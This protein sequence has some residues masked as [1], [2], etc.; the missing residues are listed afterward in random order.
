MSEVGWWQAEA[1]EGDLQMCPELLKG[2]SH[3]L[4]CKSL[5]GFREECPQQWS[6]RGGA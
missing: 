2:R 1:S 5:T 6:C 4:P 3:W